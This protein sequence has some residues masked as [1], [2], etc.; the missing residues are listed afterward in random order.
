MKLNKQDKE[1]L[2]VHI[3]MAIHDAKGLPDASIHFDKDLLEELIFMKKTVW[4]GGKPVEIKFPIH[5]GAF[6]R[7]IDLSEVSFDSVIWNKRQFC[8]IAGISYHD[9]DSYDCDLSYTNAHIDFSK[10]IYPNEFSLN[11]EESYM[12]IRRINFAGI[13]LTDSHIEQICGAEYTSFK[14]TKGDFSSIF[15]SCKYFI[16]CDFEG[17]VTKTEPIVY[18]EFVDNFDGCNFSHTGIHIVCDIKREGIEVGKVLADEITDGRL[19]QCFVNN[20]LI[21]SDNEETK[22]NALTEYQAYQ[23]KLCASV[24][25]AIQKEIPRDKKS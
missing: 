19:E 4:Q 22:Q 25:A 20:V 3:Q 15:D 16:E 1:S 14:E 7:K 17:V 6:L 10:A 9:A 18:R 5:T 23:K 21:S 11:P 12:L 13:D 24:D 2:I 8:E